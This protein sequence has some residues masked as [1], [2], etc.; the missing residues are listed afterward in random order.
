LS[1]VSFKG[2][3]ACLSAA[4][5]APPVCVPSALWPLADPRSR[6]SPGCPDCAMTP[7]LPALTLGRQFRTSGRT[8]EQA[9]ST[10]LEIKTA[11]YLI[12]PPT[13]P[14]LEIP[15]RRFESHFCRHGMTN[16]SELRR[17]GGIE[18]AGWHSSPWPR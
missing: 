1:I 8:N 6:V 2:S 14:N 12:D 10:F 7:E 4:R 3:A 16:A 9:S 11:R 17:G 15:L 13:E 18:G 5:P